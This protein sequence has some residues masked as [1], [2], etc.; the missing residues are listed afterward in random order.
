MTT[1]NVPLA[2]ASAAA[3]IDSP[4]ARV[5]VRARVAVTER[6]GKPAAWFVAKTAAVRADVAAF[7][8]LAAE[9]TSLKA[10]LAAQ[11]PAERRVPA[12][13]DLVKAV[14]HGHNWTFG[15]LTFGAST[16]LYL[17]AGVLRWLAGHPAR[18]WVAVAVAAAIGMWLA[19]AI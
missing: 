9:P 15:A 7:W 18:F 8:L 12:G 17:A 4:G 13:N 5:R 19:A 11:T 16:F 3:V 14:W 10:W 2:G 1:T 6:G